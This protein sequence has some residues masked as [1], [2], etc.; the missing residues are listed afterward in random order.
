MMTLKLHE[1]ASPTK[2]TQ[3]VRQ[4]AETRCRV[5]APFCHDFD[6]LAAPAPENSRL[7]CVG[8]D[9]PVPRGHEREYAHASTRRCLCKTRI[10]P[11]P[12]K[13]TIG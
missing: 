9:N 2:G 3:G 7:S 6:A 4:N 11:D 5:A 12:V 13:P 1:N 10:L 8:T